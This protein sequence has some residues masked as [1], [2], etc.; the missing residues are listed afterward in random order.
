VRLYA[1]EALAKIGDQSAVSYLRAAL[2]QQNRFLGLF[3]GELLSN[4][5]DRSAIPLL[6]E[7]LESDEDIRMR[8]YAAWTLGRLGDRSGL[9]S[10]KDVLKNP[11]AHLRANAA[12]TLGEIGGE[13]ATALLK[14]AL[15]DT[16]SPVKMHAVW[17]LDRIVRSPAK[18][19]TAQAKAS[20]RQGQRGN[21]E[22]T[23]ALAP[24]KPFS[25]STQLPTRTLGASAKDPRERPLL[26]SA[27]SQRSRV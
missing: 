14:A 13:E 27:P 25:I 24:E 1:A 2:N 17:A 20:F 5:G 22:I 16:A 11:D 19:P 18:T 8:L 4:L 15:R 7:A 9:P 3:A 12:W 10:A 21:P 26:L 6:R 23:R